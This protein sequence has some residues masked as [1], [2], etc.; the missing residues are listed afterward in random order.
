MNEDI[1]EARSA[2]QM[3]LGRLVPQLARRDGGNRIHRRQQ[4]DEIRLELAVE[5]VRPRLESKKAN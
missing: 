3:R 4:R 5:L 2:K 1:R